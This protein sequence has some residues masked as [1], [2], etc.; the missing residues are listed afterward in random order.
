MPE[1]IIHEIEG[2]GGGVWL[3]FLIVNSAWLLFLTENK[4]K[5]NELK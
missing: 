2:G 5:W 3:V 4:F 1:E